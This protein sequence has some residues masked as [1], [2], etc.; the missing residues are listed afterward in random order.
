MQMGHPHT[1]DFNA[2]FHQTCIM[3][4]SQLVLKMEVIDF[5]FVRVITHYRYGLQSPNLHQ[6][7]ILGYSQLV[8]KMEVIDLDLQQGCQPVWNFRILYGF[9]MQNTGVR[10]WPSKY[11]NW[12]LSVLSLKILLPEQSLHVLGSKSVKI[13]GILCFK[14]FKYLFNHQNIHSSLFHM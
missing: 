8:L 3:E 10:I 14:T 5:G 12:A 6:T 7:C 4:H 13:C 11:G 9:Y 1:G 2:M